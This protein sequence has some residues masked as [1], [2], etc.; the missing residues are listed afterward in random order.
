MDHPKFFETETEE[1][2]AKYDLL[3]SIKGKREHLAILRS[4]SRDIGTAL[5]QFGWALSEAGW[6]L[7]EGGDFIIRNSNIAGSRQQLVKVPKELLNTKVI[8]LLQEMEA[9]RMEI[10]EV[11]QLGEEL[12]K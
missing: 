6:K 2:A 4:R 5:Q 8:D 10:A 9:T 3:V 1:K 12:T 11:S 7:N